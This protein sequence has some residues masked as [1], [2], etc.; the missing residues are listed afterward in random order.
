MSV[1]LGLAARVVALRPGQRVRVAVDGGSATGKTTFAD[2]LAARVAPNRP[3]VRTSVDR[4]HR[5]RAERY[6]QGPTSA[7]GCYED[8]YDHGAL[9]G[10]L[11]DPFAAG[12]RH[13]LGVWDWLADRPVR[14]PLEQAPDDAVLV[15]DGVFLQRPEL[16]PAWDL[17]VLLVATPDEVLRRAVLRDAVHFGTP[18][19]VVE[20]Y[21][22]RYLPAEALYAELCAPAQRA[23]VVVDNDNPTAPV[24]LRV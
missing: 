11:L 9:L 18:E 17:T 10:E 21:R 12:A 20:R 13:R 22:T 16:A 7:R 24:L 6:R 19:A 15:V 2:A 1:L 8:T 3:V 23:D 14:A 4:F 5:P